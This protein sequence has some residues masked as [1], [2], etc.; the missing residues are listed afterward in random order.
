MAKSSQI[1]S[2]LVLCLGLEVLYDGL[3]LINVSH[4]CHMYESSGD[5]SSCQ[6]MV[7]RQRHAGTF[8]ERRNVLGTH[9][10]N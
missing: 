4:L 1:G 5:V 7:L 6:E 10:G 9:D 2:Y 3:N 8:N